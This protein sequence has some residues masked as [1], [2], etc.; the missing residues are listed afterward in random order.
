MYRGRLS[1]HDKN[2]D[3]TR[4]TNA[5]RNLENQSDVLQKQI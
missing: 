2:L 1:E 5:T 4:L 3:Q